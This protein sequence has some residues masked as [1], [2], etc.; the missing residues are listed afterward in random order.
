MWWQKSGYSAPA[1]C[2]FARGWRGWHA[3]GESLKKGDVPVR[4]RSLLPTASGTCPTNSYSCQPCVFAGIADVIRQG[5]SVPTR[6]QVCRPTRAG[7]APPTSHPLPPH[8]ARTPPP[9]RLPAP[10]ACRRC[11][12]SLLAHALVHWT[13][14]A[15]ARSR[16]RL[17]CARPRPPGSRRCRQPPT[18]RPPTV[19]QPPTND[20]PPVPAPTHTPADPHPAGSGRGGVRRACRPARLP[21]RRPAAVPPP[22]NRPP[23]ASPLPILACLHAMLAGD[24]AG[25]V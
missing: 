20:L 22:A 24:D 10:H 16:R 21:V 2:A 3:V 13:P 15:N 7:R 6:P 23:T 12:P 17:G 14:S 1:P 11:R 25:R 19:C 9:N 18:K 8:T 5:L 4:A